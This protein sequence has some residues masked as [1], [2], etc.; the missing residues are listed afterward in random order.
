MVQQITLDILKSI[1]KSLKEIKDALSIDNHERGSY[2][3]WD[4]YRIGKSLF[5]IQTLTYAGATM[6]L[7]L[8][9]TKAVQMNRL[10]QVWN[11]ATAR[12]LS[13]RMY[14]NASNSAYV[15]L[16][17]AAANTALNRIIQAGIEYK[18][19][20]GSRLQFYYSNF[21]V[22]KTVTIVVQADEL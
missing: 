8:D 21:T 22:G 4:Y 6:T 19:T 15:E 2:Q 18:Y 5:F 9:F 1:D 12:D 14:S 7:N 16:D 10:E 11:D 13:L 3:G 20:A 17:N